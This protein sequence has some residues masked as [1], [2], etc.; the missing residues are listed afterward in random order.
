PG[1]RRGGTRGATAERPPRPSRGR[2]RGDPRAG[3]R[4]RRRGR[5]R[6]RGPRR[7]GGRGRRRRAPTARRRRTRGR[8][9][10]GGAGRAS[11]PAGR[12]V[13]PRR[14]LIAFLVSYDGK[15]RKGQGRAHM[16]GTMP[17]ARRLPFGAEVTPGRGVAFRVWAPR[18]K[19]VEVV[20]EGGP[21]RVL[22]AD[23]RG[24]FAGAVGDARAGRRYRFRLGGHRVAPGPD[25]RYQP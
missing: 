15:S 12:W 17:G 22:D 1:F 3:R 20:I 13:R 18:R 6:G 7:E 19:K 24:W 2:A 23:G 5:A 11:A 25:S 4:R 9:R 14:S 21:A 10:G 8:S 16:D